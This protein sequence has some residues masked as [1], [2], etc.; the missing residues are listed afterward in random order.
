MEGKKMSLV[1]SSKLQPEFNLELKVRISVMLLSNMIPIELNWMEYEYNV[2]QD[3]LMSS[4]E[5]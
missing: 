3:N 5:L 1:M 2:C 4:P